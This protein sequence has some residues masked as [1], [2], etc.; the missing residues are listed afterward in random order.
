VVHVPN[1]E[2][3]LVYRVHRSGSVPVRALQIVTKSIR[4][5]VPGA[6]P[7]FTGFP[8]QISGLPGSDP[9]SRP[10]LLIR[11]YHVA[12]PVVTGAPR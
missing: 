8:R 4:P 9:L 1:P 11:R 3:K 6:R 10:A 2:L 12:G 7:L 5:R